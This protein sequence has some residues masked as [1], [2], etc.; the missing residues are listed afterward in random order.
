MTS[1]TQPANDQGTGPRLRGNLGTLE[2]FFSIMAYNAPLVV[3]VGIIPIMLVAGNG[4]GTPL[5]FIISGIILAAFADGFI[6]MSK[7]LPR[8]GAF[9]SFITAGLGREVGLGSGFTMLV[10]YFCVAS[11]TVAFGGIV[12]GALVTDT[13]H[14]PSAPWYVW[15]AV[16]WGL[17]AVLGY[18]RIDLSAKITT[19]LL[20]GELVVVAVYDTAVILHGGGPDDL[21][22][23]P[24]SPAHLFDGSFA[25]G[26]LFAMGMFGGFEVAVLFRDE[27][28]DPRRAIPRAT[29]GVIAAAGVLYS[30]TSWLFIDSLGVGNAVASVLADPEGVMHASISE[31]AGRF[32]T[33]AANVLVNTSAFAV[34]L[35]AHNVAS[36]YV[37]NLSADGILPRALSGVHQRHGSPHA[38]S[39]AMSVAT[40]VIFV[41]IV[42]LDVEPL[43][44]YAAILGIA[45]VATLAVFFA[46][47]SR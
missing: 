24:F 41:P 16:F 47:T 21:S 15:G 42:V 2:L 7:A 35:T 46:A 19:L 13:L 17:T 40:A 4:V 12:L 11:G 27:V 22:A 25:I 26:I 38:A 36:R 8:P 31:F 30:V 1:T 20:F 45:S 37:F 18:L 29:F 43:A 28:R 32:T 14:G 39:L 6:R 3:V 10:A 5:V 33:D 23:A 34:L 9:Y 44:F